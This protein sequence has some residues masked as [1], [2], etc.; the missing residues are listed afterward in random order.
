MHNVSRRPLVLLQHL[1]TT[2]A[3]DRNM[4]TSSR[5]YADAIDALNSLQTPHAVIEAR[6]KAGI[7]PDASSMREMRAYL[8]RIGY[9]PSDLNRLNVVHVA[10]T[11]GKGSTCAF[12]DSILSQYRPR[13]SKT[14]LFI[15]PHLIAVRERIRINSSPLSEE[16]FAKYFFQVWDRLAK[17]SACPEDAVPGS[18]PLYARY[19]TL[20]SW[21]AFLSEGVDIAVY[22][23]GIGGEFDATNLVEKPV[24]SGISTLGIDHTFVLGDTVEKIAWH[25]AGIMK[26][27][28][29]AFTVKQELA[30]SD[31]LQ[32]RA[33]E[34]NVQLT[35]LS[36]DNK[37]LE[38]V[39]IRPDAEFQKKNATLAINLAEAAL[40]KL[41]LL[42]D[43]STAPSALPDKFKDGLEGTVF[44]GRCEIKQEESVTW[45]VDGAHTAESLK[46]SSRWFA[47]ETANST[48]PRILIFNQ[49]GRPEAID[50]LAPIQRTTSRAPSNQPAFDHAIFCT[51]VTLAKA[52]Y[53]RDFVNHGI[54]PSEVESMSVQ[55]RLAE[56]WK[57]L[58]PH[59]KV[60][61]LPTIEEAL[62]YARHVAEGLEGGKKLQVYVTG[63]LHLVGGVLGLLE[64]ADAL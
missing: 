50:F 1:V 22:E 39:K 10:G 60:A 9:T 28:S 35:V 7:R 11:K 43:S 57:G 34:K 20:M 48:N 4:A 56:K 18:R 12:V 17:S 46:M 16:L 23:T 59:C 55:R 49:Q 52:G 29:P 30:A 19:L 63:S 51:N 37:R 21:H 38:D 54:D 31:V 3:R 5:T 47:D 64:E 40:T 58:D 53:K 15:S 27:G 41:G 33:W 6:R 61:I 44:R 62:Q 8:A 13:L 2:R 36:T 42:T 32:Q 25:K 14:G 45:Y 26:E 24:A